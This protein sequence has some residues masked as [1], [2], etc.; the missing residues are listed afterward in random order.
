M[1]RF[2]HSCT[3]CGRGWW[4]GVEHPKTC[5]WCNSSLWN[6]PRRRE[7]GAGRRGRRVLV[8]TGGAEKFDVSV[9]EP[10]PFE[11]D[12]Q[13]VRVAR[14]NTGT[15]GQE[16]GG[17]SSAPDFTRMALA[18][19]VEYH[20]NRACAEE[21]EADP[22]TVRRHVTQK[23]R[24]LRRQRAEQAGAETG[25]TGAQGDGPSP[26]QPA[27][28]LTLDEIRAQFGLKPASGL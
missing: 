24:D 7:A 20:V 3:R 10:T 4:S 22:A 18:Q 16:P 6:T 13:R 15:H 23:V 19:E 5:R 11:A 27:T 2:E 8:E 14:F 28:K 1:D 25:S 21:P 17:G 26:V 9:A 12:M